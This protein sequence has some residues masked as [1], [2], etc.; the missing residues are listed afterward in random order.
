MFSRQTFEARRIV[1]L[2]RNVLRADFWRSAQA[3][4]ANEHFP[5]AKR[6]SGNQPKKQDLI[7]R[8]GRPNEV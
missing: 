2:R 5:W 3:K 1:Q 6:P 7:L 8:G 4:N